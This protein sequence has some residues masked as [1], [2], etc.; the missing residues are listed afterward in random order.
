MSAAAPIDFLELEPLLKARLAQVKVDGRAI[1]IE[2]YEEMPKDADG[3]FE[4]RRVPCL[5]TIYEGY[6]T[7]S[8]E[9]GKARVQQIWT[10][11]VA[12]ANVRGQGRE[13]AR[14]DAGPII[15]QV[16]TALMGW[17]PQAA[18]LRG[19]TQMQLA[20]PIYPP[21]YKAKV[22]LFPLA[23][24]TERPVHGAALNKIS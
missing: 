7:L 20:D 22:S 11:S 9:A 18:G 4:P 1:D 24:T 23:F 21:V 15:G 19:Y 6:R 13:D 5:V 16:L 8:S 2:S 17:F 10:V 12:V 14:K 3:E